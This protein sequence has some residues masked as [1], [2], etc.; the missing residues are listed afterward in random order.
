[1]FATNAS[2]KI[3]LHTH[4]RIGSGVK[5]SVLIVAQDFMGWRKTEGGH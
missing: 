2:K 4:K 1:M 5:T 3:I